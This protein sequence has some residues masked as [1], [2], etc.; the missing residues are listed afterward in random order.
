MTPKKK[1]LNKE[2]K[3]EESLFRLTK[4]PDN[5]S[6]EDVTFHREKKICLVCK[7]EVSRINYICPNCSALYCINCSK[8]LT[9]LENVC[10]VCNEPFDP[11]KPSKPY[12]EDE[13]KSKKEKSEKKT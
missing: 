13:K 9:K 11:L 3:I 10:W 2:I 5:I 6:E 7:G 1:A 4:R 8:E 12:K